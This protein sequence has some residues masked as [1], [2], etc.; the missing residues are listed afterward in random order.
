MSAER[1][2]D[3]D[4]YVCKDEF[5]DHVLRIERRLSRLEIIFYINIILTMTTLLKM[6]LG[7]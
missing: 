2:E 4:R 3:G 1:Q 6:I 5:Y 7:V